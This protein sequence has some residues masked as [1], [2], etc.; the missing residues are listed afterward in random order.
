MAGVDTFQFDAL[1]ERLL[2]FEVFFFG[3]AMCCP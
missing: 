3:T 1:L 2:D